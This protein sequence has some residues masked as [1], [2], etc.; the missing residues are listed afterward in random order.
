MRLFN[1]TDLPGFGPPRVIR[2]RGVRIA[3]GK[4]LYLEDAPESLRKKDPSVSGVVL[5]EGD[6]LPSPYLEFRRARD[7]A[8]KQMSWALAKKNGFRR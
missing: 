1:L 6:S 4:S 2:F 8:D 5:T 3:P 7:T